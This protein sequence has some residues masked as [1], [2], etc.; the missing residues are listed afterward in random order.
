[1]GRDRDEK[2]AQDRECFLSLAPQL[3]RDPKPR[4]DERRVGRMARDGVAAVGP[5]AH[6]LI[7]L[8]QRQ[9]RLGLEAPQT[10]D[11]RGI[12]R[13]RT[14][15]RRRGLARRDRDRADGRAAALERGG[16]LLLHAGGAQVARA[17]RDVGHHEQALG[18]A[19]IAAHWA[20][21]D[22]RPVAAPSGHA[23]EQHRDD[24][25]TDDRSKDGGARHAERVPPIGLKF[26]RGH[27]GAG[28][29]RELHRGR[30]PCA[31]ILT[32]T[33]RFPLAPLDAV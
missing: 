8:R 31:A 24:Q 13:L 18:I 30:G 16:D 9:D 19:A 3:A 15:R 20:R 17:V 12:A 4:S 32:V 2:T 22:A 28:D 11:D 25:A 33:L 26:Q 23:G 6:G 21:V 14:G 1:M 10:L 27:R 5:D 7:D 29:R